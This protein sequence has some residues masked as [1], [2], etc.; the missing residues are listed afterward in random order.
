[1]ARPLRIDLPGGCHH[2][3][4]RGNQ[5]RV[6]F[7]DDR[8]RERFVTLPAASTKRFG[9]VIHA[10]VLMP[11]HYHLLLETTDGGLSRAMQWI[12]LSYGTGSIADTG[13]ADIFFRG[14]SPP[15]WSSSSD[16]A[17]R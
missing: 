11:N 4:A 6:I 9:L 2:V 12:N 16:G 3:T 13:A 1:M 14:V 17:S 10:W 7:A 15:P 8:D 5:R